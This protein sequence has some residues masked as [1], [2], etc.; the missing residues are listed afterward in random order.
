LPLHLMHTS[1]EFNNKNDNDN[2]KKKGKN[3]DT[4]NH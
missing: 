2:Y 4:N 3:R 1:D